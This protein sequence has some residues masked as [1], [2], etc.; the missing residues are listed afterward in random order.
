MTNQIVLVGP[1]PDG[2]GIVAALAT[3]LRSADWRLRT[4]ALDH[5]HSDDYLEAQVFDALAVVD[6]EVLVGG[7]SLGARIAAQIANVAQVRALLAFA[8]PFHR[9]SDPSARHGLP[10][11]LQLRV[12]TLIVQGTR[13]CYGSL[14]DLRGYGAFPELVSVK[15]LKDASHQYQ[16]RRSSDYQHDDY[17]AQ[18]ASYALDFLRPF[19]LSTDA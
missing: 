14:G 5:R 12:P 19:L 15:W 16:G 17:V 2:S 18:A 8:Y 4:L 1:H 11:I 3:H 9:R 13:D 7:Y 10:G 6:G